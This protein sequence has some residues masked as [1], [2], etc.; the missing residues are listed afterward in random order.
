MTLHRDLGQNRDCT[1]QHGLEVNGSTLV[2]PRVLCCSHLCR[3]RILLSNMY[4]A[5]KLVSCS[6]REVEVLV[7]RSHLTTHQKQQDFGAS[8]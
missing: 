5:H 6:C 4:E 8:H 3:I 1:Q 2:V 7:D